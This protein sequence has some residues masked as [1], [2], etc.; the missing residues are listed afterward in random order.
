MWGHILFEAH[1]AVLV[2]CTRSAVVI[3]HKHVHCPTQLFDFIMVHSSHLAHRAVVAQWLER[4]SYTQNVV[5][6][7]AKVISEDPISRKLACA[8]IL[9]D[10]YFFCNE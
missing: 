9:H 8:T 10:H 5:G 2:H 7:M 4:L 1:H 3:R 6:S